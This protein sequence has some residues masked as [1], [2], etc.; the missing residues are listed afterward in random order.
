MEYIAIKKPSYGR[1]MTHRPTHALIILK[2]I[3]EIIRIPSCIGEKGDI[4]LQGSGN[5]ARPTKC[6]VTS[7]LVIVLLKGGRLRV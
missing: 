6:G 1:Y 5:F 3:R 4:P 2:T 7:V